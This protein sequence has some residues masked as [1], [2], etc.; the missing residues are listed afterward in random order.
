MYKILSV[1]NLEKV[2]QLGTSEWVMSEFFSS[3]F[4]SVDDL[5]V[6]N[7]VLNTTKQR[8]LLRLSE[9]NIEVAVAVYQS[10]RSYLED[11]TK[12]R[13]E[14]DKVFKAPNPKSGLLK[15]IET[16]LEKFCNLMN[17][18]INQEALKRAELQ[19]AA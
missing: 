13:E 12:R 7:F 18:K 4:Y 11:A 17:R 19:K 3:S 16:G 14:Y 5:Q 10:L 1:E 15:M 8:L 9:Y 2:V 6:Y